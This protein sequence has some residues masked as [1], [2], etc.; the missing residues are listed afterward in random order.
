MNIILAGATSVVHSHPSLTT[1]WLMTVVRL[2]SHDPET[3]CA[4][5][6]SLRRPFVMSLHCRG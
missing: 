4:Y 3:F 1:T 2:V 6:S 5:V